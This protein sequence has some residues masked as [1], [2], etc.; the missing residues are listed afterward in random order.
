MIGDPKQAIYAFR[1]ADVFAYMKARRDAGD[2]GYTLDVNWR[3]DPSL[4]TAVNTLFARVPP[5]LRLR[6]DPLPPR[7][8]GARGPGSRRRRAGGR[9]AAA[10]PLL[11][12]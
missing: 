9:R 3:S 6:R 4:I 7:R 8:P 1:G 10:D 11:R 5:P 12:A 2:H